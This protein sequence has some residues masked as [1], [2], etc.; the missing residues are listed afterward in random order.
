MIREI[1]TLLLLII[2][3]GACYPE[4]T[5]SPPIAQATVQSAWQANQ[6]TVW[7][8]EWAAI[9]VGGPLTVETWRFDDRYRY[10]IL[11][12]TAPALI[13][14]TLVFDGDKGWRANRFSDSLTETTPPRLAPISEI[15]TIV[16]DFLNRVP[17]T[18][19]QQV[20]EIDQ[21]ATQQIKLTFENDES[22]QFRIDQEMQLPMRIIIYLTQ[23]EISLKVRHAEPLFDPPD[24]LFQLRRH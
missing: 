23:S 8:I 11:E 21:K 10:E 20:I 15:F 19:T 3:L 24:A 17:Q 5:L 7:E 1:L 12:A 9:P 2:F 16:D 6:H 4:Q 18:A 14:E 22:L 13:G